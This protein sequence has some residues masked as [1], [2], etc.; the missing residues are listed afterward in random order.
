ML[1]TYKFIEHWVLDILLYT[2]ILVR[3]LIKELKD[4]RQLVGY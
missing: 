2:D 4:F 3:P 1:E